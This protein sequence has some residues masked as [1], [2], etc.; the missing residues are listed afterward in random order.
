M[1]M[2][3]SLLLVLSSF[4][5]PKTLP[6]HRVVASDG[7]TLSLPEMS[8]AVLGNTRAASAVLDKRRAL[9]GSGHDVVLGDITAT[10]VTTGLNAVFLLGDQVTASTPANWRNFG[11]R[12]ASILDGTVAPPT[13]MRRLP[14]LPV[15]G[16]RDCVKEPSCVTLA[17]VFPGFGVEIGFGRV[18]TWHHLDV[19]IGGSD[20]WRIIVLDSNKKG[21]G[22]RWHE[23]MSWL[24]G[25]A[26]SPGSGLIVLMHDS[27]VSRTGRSKN[28]GPAELME[29]IGEHAPLLSL[30]AVFSAG[31]VNHQAFL[32]EGALGPLH[33]VAGAGGAPG[34]DL[35]RGI[36]GK[37][38]EPALLAGMEKGL[39]TLVD[40]HLFNPVPPEQKAIDEA[41]GKGTFEGFERRVDSS[42]F[43]MH[44]WWKLHFKPGSIEV[45]WRGQKGD[46]TVAQLASVT[47]TRENGW[48]EDL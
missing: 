15:V 12:H 20:T 17:K 7:T 25:V 33:V 28:T 37:V 8:V 22:S 43:P 19:N 18:A 16:D 30:R 1:S 38:D 34:V 10:S 13:A 9:S 3:F 21:L 35:K 42:V 40:S 14:V 2:L 29:A 41:L 39:N 4:A 36:A 47:W 5:A 24:K 11:E 46:A 6:A 44:G 48:V 23:Q 27:P 26:A 31:T 32:P 45:Q